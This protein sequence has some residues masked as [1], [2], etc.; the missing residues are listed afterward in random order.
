M[1]LRFLAPGLFA[2]ALSAPAASIPALAEAKPAVLPPAPA[3]APADP[4]PAAPGAA[5][6]AQESDPDAPVL[7]HQE[8]LVV[9]DVGEL[10]PAS[11]TLLKLPL[12][13]RLL[14]ASVDV[15]GPRLLE[16][17][18]ARVLGDAL[19]DASG[20]AVHSESGVADF[21]VLR[22]FDSES[23]ALVTTDGAPEP[24][25]T[26]YHLYNAERV[27]V[28]KGPASFLYGGNPLAGVVNIVRRQPRPGEF[29]ELS[30][31]GGAFAT[32]RGTA[33]GNWSG[34]DGRLGLRLNGLWQTTDGWR[35]GRGG[36]GGRAWG[37]NPVFA[38]HPRADDSLT[39][40]VER[41]EN[42]YQPDAGLPLVGDQVARVPATRSYQSPFDRSDQAL[43]RFQLDWEQRLGAL[44]LHDKAYYRDLSWL[45]NGTLLAGVFPDL[46]GRL[47]VARA[48]ILLDDRQAFWGNQLEASLDAAAGGLT[49]HLL[50]GLELA[51][52]GD[53]FSLDVGFLPGIDL[54]APQETARGPVFLLPGQSAA[55][56][57]RMVIAAPY[58]LD[59]IAFSERFQLLAGG[60]FD[61]LDYHD[62]ATGTVRH[63]SQ[64]SPFGGV[65]FA[66]NAQWSLY[67][68]A[69]RGFAPPSTR[70]VG[71]RRPETG[72]Q[73]E[74]GVKA[75]LLP[76]RLRGSL[77]AYNLVRRNEVILEANGFTAQT[78]SQRS[79][80][81]E[82][83]L[84]AQRLAGCEVLLTYAYDRAVFTRFAEQVLVA[85]APPAFAT[86]DRTGR[87]PPLA[88]AHIAGLWLARR[89]PGGLELG[90]GGRYVSRQFIAAD[91][92][93]AIPGAFTADA[94]LALPLGPWKARLDVK[95]LTGAK[96]W[97]R[98]LGT[99]SVIPGPGVAVYAGVEMRWTPSAGATAS[100]PGPNR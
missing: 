44:T 93:F 30:G 73:L 6:P 10:A 65:I 89:L 92:A 19:K 94:S 12:P 40:S 96:T 48:L 17:Q 76:G 91:N 95:N 63:D 37:A 3:E 67:A 54:L 22:G 74:A 97:T 41:I 78:G 60:R 62:R 21:F 57:A 15:V 20:V 24:Q 47:Q 11:T 25:T 13:T 59:R 55:G 61:H 69:G 90:A 58:L 29:V 42:A 33:D 4:A 66:P 100:S 31:Q 83:E 77:A 34:Q 82:L 8:S 53:K 28:L 7:R 52:R 68:N 87:T 32:W 46:G 18:D 43:S 2:L 39:V 36:R 38:W 9:R 45:S 80:G 79:R 99:G 75:D 50:A 23:A 98:G 64:L 35:D 1:S 16:Q 49:H 71:P 85:F 27:E 14:P 81:V 56:D 72:S 86:I 88:P 84:Q 51:R 5:R 70:V 26:F